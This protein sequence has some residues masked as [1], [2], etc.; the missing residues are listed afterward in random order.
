MKEEKYWILLSKKLNG[1]ATASELELL[2]E[3]TST[4]PEWKSIMENMVELWHSKPLEKPTHNHKAEDAYLVHINR[5]KGKAPDFKTY[6]VS[7]EY[8]IDAE[9]GKKPFYKN[10]IIYACAAVVV[11]VASVY[12]VLN[13]KDGRLEATAIKNP[14]NEVSINRGSHTKIVLPDGSQVWINS[15]SK[16]TYD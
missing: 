5:L 11:I 16:L 1:E 14:A 8:D 9:P 3:L 6:S 15:G 7:R 2:D 4:N 13:S 12:P 10:W